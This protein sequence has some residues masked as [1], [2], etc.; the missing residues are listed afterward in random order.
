MP[1]SLRGV[2]ALLNTSS[3]DQRYRRVWDRR[4][5]LVSFASFD[6]PSP[7]VF[8]AALLEVDGDAEGR[9]ACVYRVNA[10]MVDA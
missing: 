2:V 10:T 3:V 4:C 1:N 7:V 8:K 9:G 6:P 5:F